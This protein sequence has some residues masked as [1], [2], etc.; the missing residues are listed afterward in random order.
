MVHHSKMCH[1]RTSVEELGDKY[2]T[3]GSSLLSDP[4]LM[5][6]VDKADAMQTHSSKVIK[7]IRFVTLRL[8]VHTRFQNS[9]KG[10][11]VFCLIWVN[12][13]DGLVWH[14]PQGDPSPLCWHF[15]H[16]HHHLCAGFHILMFS[17]IASMAMGRLGVPGI[18]T[19]F[20][21]PAMPSPQWS[22]KAE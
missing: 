3:P 18:T 4:P 14:C 19:S 11:D 20:A 21:T 16:S 17:S 1:L 8:G 10:S 15:S 6:L 13:D 5:H 7:Q 12:V 2:T 22:W 9:E